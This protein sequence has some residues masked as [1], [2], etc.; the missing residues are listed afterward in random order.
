[1]FPLPIILALMINEIS[2]RR[3]KKVTQTI[4]YL[5][6]FI[7]WAI[8][9]TMALNWLSPSTG[10]IN[11]FLVAIGILPTPVLFLGEAKAF[12]WISALLEVWKNTGWGS[13][14]YLAAISGI[15]QEMYE[16]ALIDGATRLQRICYV[17]LPSITGTIMILLILNIGGLLSGG[18]GSSNFQISYL[19]G[20]PLNLERSEIIDTYVLKVGISLGRFSYASAVGLLNSVVSLI[21]LISANAI[22]K[23]A[24]NESFF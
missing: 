19:L 6:Y 7:S 8:V 2:S 16:A 4:S 3:Y 10:F 13:I 15:D 12:W 11:R 9:A 18:T 17:T 1:M 5:P 14:I 21:L 23:K 24:T 22:S 20:N